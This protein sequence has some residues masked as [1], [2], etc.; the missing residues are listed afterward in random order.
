MGS[1]KT[2]TSGLIVLNYLYNNANKEVLVITT[3]ALSTPAQGKLQGQFLKDWYE[4]LPFKEL[5]L[6]D[7]IKITNNHYSNFQEEHEY[8]LI[9]IDEAH[10]FLVNRL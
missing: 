2:I 8:G 3:N 9:I 6:T 10:I 1:G 4:K 7:R 5:K